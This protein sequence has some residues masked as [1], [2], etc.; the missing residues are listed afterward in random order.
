MGWW[1]NL[2]LKQARNWTVLALAQDQV[3]DSPE[4]KNIQPNESYVTVTLHSMR[5]VNVRVGWS[6]FFGA[7]HSYIALPNWAGTR[8]EFQ[9]VVTPEELANVASKNLDKV[10]VMEQPLMGPVP[11]R[12]GVLDLELGLFSVKSTDLAAP[13]LGLLRSLSEKAGVSFINTA[14]PFAELIKKGVEQVTD[15]S[16]KTSLLVGLSRKWAKPKSGWYVVMAA[17]KGSVNQNELTV[18]PHDHVLLSRDG[19]AVAGYAYMVFSIEAAGTRDEWYTI[20]EL[21]KAHNKLRDLAR[22]NEINEVKEQLAYFRRLVLTS[23]DLLQQHA[24]EVSQQVEA[25]CKATFGPTL[26]GMSAQRPSIPP[27]KSVRLSPLA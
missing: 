17:T 12:G 15:T 9:V 20:P 21:A 16:N 25:A 14:L 5:I 24:E 23:P 13:F 7:V 4:P 8:S 2:W 19:K 11:Y 6:E 27:L 26:T 10:I 1:S 18:D 3:P 22:A